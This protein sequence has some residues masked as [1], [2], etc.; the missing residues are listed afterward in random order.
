[1]LAAGLADAR[2]GEKRWRMF[3]QETKLFLAIADTNE[4]SLVL[5]EFSCTRA[6]GFI[7]VYGE[8]TDDLRIAMAE[9]VRTGQ[10]PLIHV[11]PDLH[12]IDPVVDLVFSYDGWHY[13]YSLLG[14]DE[15]FDRFRR[16]GVLE[17]KLGNVLV[18]EE[19][20]VGLDEVGKFI[21]LCKGGMP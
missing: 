19:F 16:E 2:A 6:M 7:D 9:F 1:M 13:K 21:D 10:P 20:K 18:H 12:H 15:S 3:D 14:N 4:L 17:F 11:Q 8:A 5:P